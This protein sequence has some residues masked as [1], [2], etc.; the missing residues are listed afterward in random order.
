METNDFLSQYGFF[1][2]ARYSLPFVNAVW[3]LFK[4]LRLLFRWKQMQ[5]PYE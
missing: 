3:L 5:I 1:Y 2:G 4:V